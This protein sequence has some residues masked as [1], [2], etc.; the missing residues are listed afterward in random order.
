MLPPPLSQKGALIA[1]A[2]T[3]MIKRGAQ[4]DPDD[5]NYVLT[6]IDSMLTCESLFSFHT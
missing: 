5:L 4:N 2:L 3:L 1:E 6:L